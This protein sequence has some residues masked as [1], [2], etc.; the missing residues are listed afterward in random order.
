MKVTVADLK[1]HIDKLPD[2]YEV[3]IE[4][5]EKLAIPTRTESFNNGENRI[6]RAMA[7]GVDNGHN[8]CVIFHHY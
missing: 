7:L 5:P 4:Y 8:R 1:E 3:W 2:D 6:I